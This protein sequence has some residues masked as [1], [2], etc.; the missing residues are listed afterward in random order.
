MAGTRVLFVDIDATLV[1]H[2]GRIPVSAVSAIRAA[3]QQGHQVMLATGR[4]A[5]DIWP[6]V[7]QVGFDGAVAASGAQVIVDGEQILCRTL[8]A[9]Q[10]GRVSDFFG[11]GVGEYCLQG[12]GMTWVTPGAAAIL[13]GL[14]EERIAEGAERTVVERG[15]FGFLATMQVGVLPV[16]GPVAKVGYFGAAVPL[17]DI[18]AAFDD[19]AVVP[20][21]R[22]S[23]GVSAGE[24]VDR[25]VSKASGVAAVLAHLGADR[26]DAVALGDSANDIEM[27][28]YVGTG[29]AMGNAPRSV[30]AAA[31]LVVASPCQGGVA[32]ALRTVG[33]LAPAPVGWRGRRNTVKGPHAAQG[34]VH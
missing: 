12:V 22:E 31:D 27:L 8:T 7:W 23:G 9:D 5:H 34:S 19:F 2:F 21:A 3:R 25:G 30:R 26:A 11:G 6:E 4:S 18:E 33:A 16:A 17:A 29:V 24:M 20:A 14:C 1:D 28:A 13:R 32:Q 15:S 10:L